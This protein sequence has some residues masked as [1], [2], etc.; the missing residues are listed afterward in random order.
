MAGTPG[1]ESWYLADGQEWPKRG[2]GNYQELVTRWLKK[3]TSGD[4]C[5]VISETKE[6]ASMNE[7]LPVAPALGRYLSKGRYYLRSRTCPALP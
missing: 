6:S 7:A 1:H 4:S 5:S 3:F 2:I